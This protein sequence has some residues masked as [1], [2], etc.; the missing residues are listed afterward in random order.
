MKD[1]YTVSATRCRVSHSLSEGFAVLAVGVEFRC[2]GDV[3]CGF[4][5]LVMGDDLMDW[6]GADKTG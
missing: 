5:I 6:T 1:W 2:R 4:V 3:G